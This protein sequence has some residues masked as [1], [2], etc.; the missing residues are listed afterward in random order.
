MAF[1]A[2]NNEIQREKRVHE[3]L[4]VTLKMIA[5]ARGCHVA[6]V[7]RAVESGRLDPG[8]LLSV[9]RFIR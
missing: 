5:E 2:G 4:R 6:T 3:V 9:A 1:Q 8:D 7:R